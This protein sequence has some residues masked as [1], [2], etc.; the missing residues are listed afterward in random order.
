MT[1]L[2]L[3]HCATFL[4]MKLLWIQHR[5]LGHSVEVDNFVIFVSEY[6]HKL[7]A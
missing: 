7:A 1:S 4:G 3:M 6:F 5:H 2:L